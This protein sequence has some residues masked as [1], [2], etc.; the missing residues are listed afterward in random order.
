[1][2]TVQA[3]LSRSTQGV[4]SFLQQCLPEIDEESWWQTTVLEKLSEHQSKLASQK[5]FCCRVR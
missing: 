4:L 1:M 2:M 5:G 3:Y